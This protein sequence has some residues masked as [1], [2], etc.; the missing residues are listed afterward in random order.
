MN[1]YLFRPIDPKDQYICRMFTAW[2]EQEGIRYV[3]SRNSGKTWT[4]QFILLDNTEAA[5]AKILFSDFIAVPANEDVVRFIW[6]DQLD[7][8][9][10]L[11]KATAGDK[12]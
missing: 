8:E 11:L 10:E 1:L 2:L 7:E 4:Q 6:G 3:G 5:T 9:I 12:Q